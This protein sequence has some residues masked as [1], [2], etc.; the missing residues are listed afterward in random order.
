MI[1]TQIEK[2][3]Q[4]QNEYLTKYKPQIKLYNQIFDDVSFKY[5]LAF[6]I[7]KDK[8][9][10]QVVNYELENNAFMYFL[11]LDSL[12]FVNRFSKDDNK[13]YY[14]SLQVYLGL[15]LINID[16]NNQVDI[17][18]YDKLIEH[19]NMF[20]ENQELF[21]R[22]KNDLNKI[23]NALVIK[24]DD[25]SY[26]EYLVDIGLCEDDIIEKMLTSKDIKNI[27]TQENY[28]LLEDLR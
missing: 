13:I 22:T 23:I 7:M 15:F 24:R 17:L 20:S 19:L 25:V 21:K 2:F 4:F 8:K 18:T 10:S 9:F 16:S 26:L 3:S 11:L 27:F 5:K 14:E 1:I 28:L 12:D 6:A